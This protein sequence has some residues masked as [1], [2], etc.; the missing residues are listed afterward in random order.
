MPQALTPIIPLLVACGWATL[1]LLVEAFSSSRRFVGVAWLTAIGLAVVAALSMQPLA[2]NVVYGNALALDGYAT[3]FNILACVIGIGSVLLS[4]DYLADAGIVQGEYYPLMFF[5]VAGVVVM[6]AATDL[7]VMFIGLETMSMAVY[8]LAGALKSQMRSNEASL[9]YFLL[10]A[11]ASALLLY[12]IALLYVMTGT[13]VLGGIHSALSSGSLTGTDHLVVVLGMGLV[14]I[15]LGF[16]IAAVPFHLWAPD[17][18]EG[19][20][21]SVTA[22][23]A[24]AVKAGGFA[25]LL[26]TAMVA[27]APLHEQMVPILWIAAAVTMTVGNLVALRQASLKRMLAY[28]SIAHTGYLLVGVTAGTSEAGAAVLFYLAGY[29]AMNLAA[30]GIMCAVAR[31]G[32]PR[33]AIS[34]YAGLGQTNPMLA[35]AMTVAM[36]SLT[37][38]PPLGGFIG[39]LYVFTA[40]LDAGLFWLVGIAVFNSVISAAYYLGV[41]RTMY[42]DPPAG[43]VEARPYAA[44]IVVAATVA[45][46]LLGVAPAPVL[47]AAA[48]AFEN[49]ALGG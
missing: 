45:T 11:F 46:V 7:I 10:G 29:A 36:L 20:P 19:A 47:S 42:F 49:V 27:L 28:S 8:V 15:G 12:G 37:G 5:A 22:F 1:V 24:T 21:T 31:R 44:V 32:Q 14:L 30:F 43:A 40:A 23:M 4:V 34:D 41:V 16:K 18:Y 33:E 13:T 2:A 39:K 26:R 38:I 9:K 35:V 3:Y 25:A 6:A 17:V 48:R